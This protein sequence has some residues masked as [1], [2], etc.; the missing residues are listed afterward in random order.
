LERIQKLEKEG[1]WKLGESIYGLPKVRTKFKTGAKKKKKEAAPAPGAEGANAVKVSEGGGAGAK[2][3]KSGK[4][5]SK[6]P[7]KK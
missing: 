3:S 6:S 2:T 1:K 4:P 7:K 5:A